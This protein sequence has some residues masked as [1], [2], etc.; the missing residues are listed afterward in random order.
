MEEIFCKVLIYEEINSISPRDM[1][2][3]SYQH[4]LINNDEVWLQMLTD[5][6]NTLH[7][8]KEVDVHRVFENIKYTCL[9]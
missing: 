6:N 9:Y 3:K 4:R 8:Y 5:R 1:L 2:S 7:V